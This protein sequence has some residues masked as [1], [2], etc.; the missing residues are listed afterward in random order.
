MTLLDASLPT[1]TALTPANP[2]ALE[3]KNQLLT[4][5]ARLKAERNA[6]II[7]HVYERLEVQ[8][9]A[10]FTG[11]SLGL[12][13]QAASTDADVI[14]FCGVHFMAETAKLLSPQKTVILANANAGC[15]M[16]DMITR[17]QLKAFKA[18]HPGLPVVA[19]VNT[20]ADVKAESDYCCT[21][22]NA[23][24]VVCHVLAEQAKI[25]GPD[26]LL[27]VP[28]KNLGR[29]VQGQLAQQGFPNA[30]L[31]CYD[32][33]CP[34]HLRMNVDD[35]LKLKQQHPDALIL[36]HPECDS[37]LLAHADF[38]GSTTAIVNHAHETQKRTYI[39]CTEDGVT[40]R[41]SRDLPDKLFL[42]PSR[43]AAICPNMKM[44]RLEN[45]YNALAGNVPEITLAQDV[46]D[47][48]RRC[49][50]SMMTVVPRAK[51]DAPKNLC[52]CANSDTTQ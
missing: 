2:A 46:A 37:A 6:V 30:S 52:A 19:Y 39:I 17:D 8:D 15:P 25:G 29:F 26:K 47:A 5:I 10:D 22:A 51:I 13:R 1:P 14:I 42:T 9:V 44:T 36:A 3:R 45:I 21:S 38:I 28:D 41:L 32:G 20:P 34:T 31:I 7:A 33:F 11:D 40:Q 48:A 23:V 4:D 24:D 43:T 27:F 18:Q 35:L 12:S 16:A 50:D 49:I